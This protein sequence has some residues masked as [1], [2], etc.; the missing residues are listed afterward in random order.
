MKKAWRRDGEQQTIT[1]ASLSRV[2]YITL[3][4]LSFLKYF[5]KESKLS[6]PYIL[7][8]ISSHLIS[9]FD[10]EEEEDEESVRG[11]GNNNCD[12]KIDFYKE[13]DY[14]KWLDEEQQHA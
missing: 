10:I 14:N 5:D 6:I 2:L 1:H 12:F 13:Q 3:S 8:L 11:L 9:C 4:L 7:Y